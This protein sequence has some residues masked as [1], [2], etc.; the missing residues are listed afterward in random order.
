MYADFLIPCDV[1]DA[2][3]SKE[4]KSEVKV[5]AAVQRVRSVN[6]NVGGFEMAADQQSLEKGGWIIKKMGFEAPLGGS[7]FTSCC[8]FGFPNSPQKWRVF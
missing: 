8:V 7:R 2:A 3:E 5:G 4:K 1:A 6:S